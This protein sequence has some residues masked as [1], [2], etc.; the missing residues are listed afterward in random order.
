MWY[1]NQLLLAR[2]HSPNIGVTKI[3]AERRALV[4]T[5]KLTALSHDRGG[6]V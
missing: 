4:E 1:Y 3:S 6:A 2:K 5:V